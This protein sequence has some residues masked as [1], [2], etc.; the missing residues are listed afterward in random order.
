MG[1]LPN[2]SSKMWSENELERL[3]FTESEIYPFW[4]VN[5]IEKN[6]NNFLESPRPCKNGI[7]TL[8]F[9]W[10]MIHDLVIMGSSP[11]F[12]WVMTPFVQGREDSK[13]PF[14]DG[15]EAHGGHRP[16][17][18][19]AGP[20]PTACSP[21][22]S[23]ALPALRAHRR[24][25]R[26]EGLRRGEPPQESCLWVLLW[27][28]K[29][30]HTLSSWTSSFLG[31]W[32]FLRKTW[33]TKGAIQFRPPDLQIVLGSATRIR[34]N[35]PFWVGYQLDW[36]WQAFILLLGSAFLIVLVWV[37]GWVFWFCSFLW[38]CSKKQRDCCHSEGFIFSSVS[39][40]N[41]RRR[42]L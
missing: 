34:I 36:W 8:V 7:L 11:L 6:H 35:C 33:A 25:V 13:H 42:F 23:P 31:T 26:E 29:K 20:R 38:R 30:T 1:T 28:P 22:E 27:F 4:H 18:E 2:W 5:P 16:L 12:F 14:W 10:V 21:D 3:L 15:Y 24:L 39:R 19:H 9:C 41:T 37:F 40:S 17:R 32:G